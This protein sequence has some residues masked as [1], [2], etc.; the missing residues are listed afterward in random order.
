MVMTSPDFETWLSECRQIIRQTLGFSGV[1]VD[2]MIA[3][4][5]LQIYRAKFDRGMT[6]QQCID[7]ETRY[8]NE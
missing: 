8:W 1:L 7:D 6:P 2:S 5:G 4:A 3:G